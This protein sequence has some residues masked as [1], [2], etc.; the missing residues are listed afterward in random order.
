[1]TFIVA[2]LPLFT[3]TDLIT[4]Y[5]LLFSLATLGGRS[6]CGG[7]L[8]ILL[9]VDELGGDLPLVA[10]GVVAVRVHLSLLL[11]PLLAAVARVHGFALII[12]VVIVLILV[13]GLVNILGVRHRVAE[14]I[15]WVITLVEVNQAI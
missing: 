12:V 7:R 14:T 2:F 5:C 9:H 6:P 11:G 8:E 1:M 15:A 13:L 4:V 3:F 10:A